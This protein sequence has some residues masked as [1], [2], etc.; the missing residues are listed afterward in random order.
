MDK[1]DGV[2]TNGVFSVANDKK[3]YFSQGNLQ[4]QVS[5]GLWRFAEHQYD[6][7][8]N[9]N[10]NISSTYNGWIDLFGWGTSGW[11]SGAN[12][13]QPYSTSTRNNDYYPGG[14]YLNDLTDRY[15][16]ADWGVYNKISNGGNQ[17]GLWRTL[18]RSEWTYIINTRTDASNKKG[19]ARV[20]GVNGL[21]LLPDVWTLPDGLTFISGVNNYAQNT[22]SV[23]QWSKME[24]NGA[25]FL[26]AAGGRNGT[27]CSSSSIGHYWSSSASDDNSAYILYFSSSQVRTVNDYRLF[28]NSV[29]LVFGL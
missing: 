17:A 10:E 2:L 18:T 29:R 19:T 26:P 11:Y 22:Y 25:V 27:E 24:A 23:S 21:I 9:A 4:Y 14:S 20:N 12:A 15:A 3:V 7:M 6:I 13:Y 1:K 8:G 5:T 28:G 16:N